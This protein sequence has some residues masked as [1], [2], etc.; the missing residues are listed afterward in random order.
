VEGPTTDLAGRY[1]CEELDA[2][3]TVIGDK[4]VF[5]GAFS[6]FLGN[7][8]ME[9]LEPIGFDV[10]ALPCPRALDHTAPGDW[11]LVVQRDEKKHVIGLDVG[12]WLARRLSYRRI[13]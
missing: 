3:I 12:C 10:V 1:H 11:T 13:S 8:R 5:Y 7:S 2:E 6:G 4:E 9:F